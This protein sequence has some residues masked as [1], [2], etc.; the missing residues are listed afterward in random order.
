MTPFSHLRR[1]LFCGRSDLMSMFAIYCDDSGTDDESRVA[2]VAG[3]V[4]KV[5]KWEAFQ[6]EWLK[7]LRDFG[8]DTMHRVDL[9]GFKGEFETWNNPLRIKFLQRIQP[10]IRDHTR[11]PIGSAVIKADF[12]K[13]IPES[14]TAKFG[15]VYGWCTHDCLVAMHVW[16]DAQGYRNPVDWIFEAGTV[17]HG[18]VDA[19]FQ[20]LYDNPKTRAE[21]HIK[22]WSF[23]GKSLVPLQA[24]DVLAYE[25]FKQVTN[26]ILDKGK[27]DKGKDRNVRFSMKELVHA[28]DERYLQYWGKRRLLEWLD[29]WNS[30]RDRPL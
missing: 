22:G 20:H 2:A 14:V 5:A 16:Y 17:G 10:I 8:I 30:R 3:Y 27:D 21:Y 9:E 18:Q 28:N 13:I 25:V 15:G 19:L 24:A 23:Q 7:A 26:Q 4:G 29:E 12:E 6:K 11:Y 1:S